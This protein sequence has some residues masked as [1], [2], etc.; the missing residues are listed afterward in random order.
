M[1]SSHDVINANTKPSKIELLGLVYEHKEALEN[2]A[3]LRAHNLLDK[4][5]IAVSCVWVFF[6]KITDILLVKKSQRR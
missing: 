3:T 2:M 6:V 1:T 4:C 5:L